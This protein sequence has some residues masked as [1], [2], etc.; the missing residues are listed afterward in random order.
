M[1]GSVQSDFEQPYLQGGHFFGE[2]D[3]SLLEKWTFSVLASGPFAQCEVDLLPN[4]K[5]TFSEVDLLLVPHRKRS[6]S[7]ISILTYRAF[8]GISEILSRIVF[9]DVYSYQ[10]FSDMPSKAR[11]VKIQ[12]FEKVHLFKWTFSK[13]PLLEIKVHF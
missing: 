11:L 2:V 10:N 9:L 3:L 8:D 13:G 7:K 5:W 4:A 1:S 12:N 6:T